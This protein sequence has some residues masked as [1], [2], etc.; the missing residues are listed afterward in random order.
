MISKI[1][2]LGSLDEAIKGLHAKTGQRTV[3][4][5]FYP[6]QKASSFFFDKLL[7]NFTVEEIA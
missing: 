3:E 6:T 1:H 5:V 2:N 4:N 7:E